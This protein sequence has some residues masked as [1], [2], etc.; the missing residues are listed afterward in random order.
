MR[1]LTRKDDIQALLVEKRLYIKNND[2][3]H[4][5][6]DIKYPIYG[7]IFKFECE[8]GL[9]HLT[10][11]DLL[12]RNTEGIFVKEK[13]P[14]SHPVSWTAPT[15]FW[16]DGETAI[17]WDLYKQPNEYLTR[18]HKAM[19][20]DEENKIFKQT[21]NKTMSKQ[22]IELKEGM[23]ARVEGGKVIIE[24]KEWKPKAGDV[25]TTISPR[26]KTISIYKSGKTGVGCAWDFYASIHYANGFRVEERMVDRFGDVKICPSTYDERCTFFARLVAEG[27]KWNAKKLKLT[28]VEKWAPKDGEFVYYA[29]NDKTNEA[30]SIYKDVDYSY[31]SILVRSGRLESST[32]PVVFSKPS[33]AATDSERKQLL[34]ALAKAGKRWNA[35]LKMVENIKPEYK[36]GDFLRTKSGGV[37]IYKHKDGNLVMDHAFLARGG[38][39]IMDS[40]PACYMTSISGYA[41]DG[42]KQKLLDALAK[43]GKFWNATKKCIE[44]IKPTVVEMTME[45]VCE[46]LGM[47]V[48][49][50]K[51]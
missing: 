1:K 7:K 19:Q 10:D 23:T 50:V 2:S 31:A 37:F 22:E 38:S 27:Y 34:D 9:T 43:D 29:E 48:K 18:I 12:Y 33:R 47:N 36:D 45:Q 17:Y 44:D 3:Y 49:I 40:S 32:E 16:T 15:P 46:K 41:T 24:T 51:K 13:S 6:N 42:Q 30:V 5:V 25:V 8:G 21:T 20:R 39:L 35:E 11:I 26:G 4:R 28:K 14:Y